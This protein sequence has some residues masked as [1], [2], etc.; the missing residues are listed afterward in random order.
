MELLEA[1]EKTSIHNRQLEF[2]RMLVKSLKKTKCSPIK[3]SKRLWNPYQEMQMIKVLCQ[4]F[5]MFVMDGKE[6]QSS[7]MPLKTLLRSS[8]MEFLQTMQLKVHLV[9]AIFWLHLLH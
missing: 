3:I 2:S 1:K 8:K 7:R 9:I 5:R 6:L 4:K